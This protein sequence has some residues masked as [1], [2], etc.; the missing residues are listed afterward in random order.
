MALESGL[1]IQSNDSLATLCYPEEEKE[2]EI[3]PGYGKTQEKTSQDRS[4]AVDQST[5]ERESIKLR[6]LSRLYIGYT[7]DTII[8][9]YIL[10]QVASQ[11]QMQREETALQQQLNVCRSSYSP[12]HTLTQS[13]SLS[14][15]CPQTTQTAMNCARKC[16]LHW[17][18]VARER[19][20]KSQILSRNVALP[21]QP[22]E[23]APKWRATPGPVS[24]DLWN[25]LARCVY[26]IVS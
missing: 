18:R 4:E 14:P 26:K 10:T 23:A 8:N 3:R 2:G 19:K 16:A 12:S 1:G 25:N 13:R 15:L 20:S 17:R 6:S 7:L 21:L 9:Y 5:C 22:Q 11:V 24:F